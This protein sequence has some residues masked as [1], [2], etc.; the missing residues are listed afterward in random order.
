[1][2]P[3]AFFP[4]LGVKIL[5]GGQLHSGDVKSSF[6]QS[7]TVESSAA[8]LSDAVRHDTLCCASVES[9][10]VQVEPLQ[11]AEEEEPLYCCFCEEVSVV[12]Q[13]QILTNVDPKESH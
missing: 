9:P 13:G 11:L 6:H 4:P 1:M 7:L 10:G 3:M 5:S 12:G 2:I 8:N